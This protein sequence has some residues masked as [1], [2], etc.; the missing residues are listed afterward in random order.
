MNIESTLGIIGSLIAIGTLGW[1]GFKL[2]KKKDLKD[3]FSKLAD[4]NTSVKE[5]RRILH[6]VNAFLSLIGHSIPLSYISNFSADGRTKLTIFH[7]ICMDNDIEPTAEICRKLVG[8][9]EPKFRKEWTEAK[10]GGILV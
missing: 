10:R 9:D 3:L 2:L 8:A 4:K 6:K 5:Q 1:Q 7:D